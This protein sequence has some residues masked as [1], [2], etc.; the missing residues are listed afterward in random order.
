MC[1][2]EEGVWR[3]TKS[4]VA[5]CGALVFHRQ[6]ESMARGNRPRLRK[7]EKHIA[8]VV[9]RRSEGQRG[10]VP[11]GGGI[12]KMEAAPAGKTQLE[13]GQRLIAVIFELIDAFDSNDGLRTGNEINGNLLIDD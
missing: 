9:G 4:D 11:L 10:F 8:G 1:R 3:E 7:Y 12:G 13:R 6:S 5:G 2:E